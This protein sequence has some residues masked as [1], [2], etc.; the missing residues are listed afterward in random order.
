MS[1]PVVW[2]RRFHAVATLAWLA[3][4]IP[5]VLWWRDSVP[6]IAL[7]SVWA[8]VAGHFGSW[9]AA[10]AEEVADNGES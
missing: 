4:V 10:R 6:W 8:N 9:Q 7:M 5:T 1:I 3:L 2:L